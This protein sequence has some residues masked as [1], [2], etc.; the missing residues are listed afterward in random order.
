MQIL[1]TIPDDEGLIVEHPDGPEQSNQA[2][3]VACL[4]PSTH[5][6]LIPYAVPEGVKDTTENYFDDELPAAVVEAC[7]P[8]IPWK[9][10]PKGSYEAWLRVELAPGIN[11]VL[12]WENSD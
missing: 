5:G 9:I 1:V 3:G 8:L 7:Q 11:G 4:Q 6:V 10:I 2:G 12:I